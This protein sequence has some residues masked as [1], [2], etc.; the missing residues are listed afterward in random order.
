MPILIVDDN[1]DRRESCRALL[2]VA[3]HAVDLAASGDHALRLLRSGLR[4]NLI[5]LDIMMPGMDGFEFRQAQL[6]DPELAQIP[7]IVC[8]GYP[9]DA[10]TVARLGAVECLQTP[11]DAER[12]LHLIDAQRLPRMAAAEPP[13]SAQPKLQR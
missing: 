10:E 8:S 1:A 9:L 5:L 12:L 3:G 13:A 11:Y 4:P 6:G 7:V 2:E